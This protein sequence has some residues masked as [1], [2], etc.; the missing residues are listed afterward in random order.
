[1]DAGGYGE[2][3]GAADRCCA[4]LL[5]VSILYPCFEQFWLAVDYQFLRE[6]VFFYELL[7][8]LMVADI[9]ID[10]SV[11]AHDDHGAVFLAGGKQL[12][13]QFAGAFAAA[14]GGVGAV[15]A[16]QQHMVFFGGLSQCIEVYGILGIVWMADDLDARIFH[17]ANQGGGVLFTGSGADTGVVEAGDSV[18]YAIQQVLPQI[19]GAAIVDDIEFSPHD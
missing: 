7:G 4:R 10:M 1:M 14:A 12:R 8:I 6:L 15:V 17:G 13:G 16:F 5:S 3:Y 19:C 9:K 18:I 11:A 2:F